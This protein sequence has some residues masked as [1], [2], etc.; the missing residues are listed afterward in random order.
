VWC[1]ANHTLSSTLSFRCYYPLILHK[2]LRL[3]QVNPP[4]CTVGIPL[5]CHQAPATHPTIHPHPQKIRRSSSLPSSL[6]L[7]QNF[8]SFYF[9]TSPS[10]TSPLAPFNFTSTTDSTSLRIHHHLPIPANDS[11]YYSRTGPSS[12]GIYLANGHL[13]Q[14]PIS[15]SFHDQVST[16]NEQIH[17]SK[18]TRH[19]LNP[20]GAR[21]RG[22]R[23]YS[24]IV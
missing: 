15:H 4:S 17:P 22:V 16:T 1:D 11:P 10:S 23:R 12:P 18:S 21:E 8:P 9:P 19:T 6:L 14:N 5:S 2:S 13:N 3:A 20:T 24:T 7:A